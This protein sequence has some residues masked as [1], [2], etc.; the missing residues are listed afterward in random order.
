MAGK[1]GRPA[2]EP[3]TKDRELVK[4]MTAAGISQEAICAVLKITR[5]T[6]EKRCRHELDTGAADANA[7]VAASMFRMATKGPYSV[8]FQA[9]KYWLACRARW[10][11]EDRRDDLWVYTRP[12]GELSD[13]EFNYV[14]V[15]NG[16]EPMDL[17]DGV[18]PFPHRPRRR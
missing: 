18:V 12:L 10:R 8:R 6:L 2:W 17:G 4:A 5:P 13:A 9:A 3:T 14:L 15:A 1:R 16:M 11:D 7:T